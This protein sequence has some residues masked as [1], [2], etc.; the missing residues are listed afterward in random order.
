MRKLG[1]KSLLITA[2]LLLSIGCYSDSTSNERS[3]KEHSEVTYT[4]TVDK[5]LF[6]IKKKNKPELL[7]LLPDK[8]LQIYR[9]FVSG[10]LGARGNELSQVYAADQISNE[11]TIAVVD[12]TA[13]DIP[14]LFPEATKFN[15][16]SLK[17]YPLNGSVVKEDFVKSLLGTIKTSLLDK[18]EMADGAPLLLESPDQKIV[19]LAEA[20]VIDDILVGGF[21]VFTLRRDKYQFELLLDIR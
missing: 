6:A 16:G 10:N 14:W 15:S 1:I 9:G 17:V 13:I 19:V 3:T 2:F 20:Q 4:Q 11:L 21:A 8:G 18:P 12:Q 7:T 5:F